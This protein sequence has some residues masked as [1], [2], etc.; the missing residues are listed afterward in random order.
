MDDDLLFANSGGD[1]APLSIRGGYEEEGVEWNVLGSTVVTA[2]DDALDYVDNLTLLDDLRDTDIYGNFHTMEPPRDPGWYQ[3]DLHFDGFIPVGTVMGIA[4]PWYRHLEWKV[5]TTEQSDG[6]FEF[7]AASKEQVRRS[8]EDLWDLIYS[9]SEHPRY[10]NNIKRPAE[11]DVSLLDSF[12]S[13]DDEAQ[14]IAAQARRCALSAVGWISWFTN[15]FHDWV[16]HVNLATRDNISKLHL[17]RTRKRG[18]LIKISRDWQSLDFGFLVGCD[19]PLLYT[20]G[21]FESNDRRFRRLCPSL[22]VSYHQEAL[23]VGRAIFNGDSPLLQGD[24]ET[25][26][27]YSKF[28]E[29]KGYDASLRED[30]FPDP[31]GAR[32]EVTVI[33]R[34]GWERRLIPKAAD[35]ANYPKLYH[36]CVVEDD[37]E[38]RITVVFWRFHSRAAVAPEPVDAD[39]IVVDYE[40]EVEEENRTEIHERFKGRYVPKLDQIFDP[41]TGVERRSPYQGDDKLERFEGEIQVLGRATDFGAQS[42]KHRIGPRASDWTVDFTEEGRSNKRPLSVSSSDTLSEQRRE[43]STRPMG[44]ESEWAHQ[45]AN[46]ASTANYKLTRQRRYVEFNPEKRSAARR[47][48]AVRPNSRARSRS[49]AFRTA[50]SSPIPSSSSSQS[51]KVARRIELP[52]RISYQLRWSVVDLE[53]MRGAWLRNFHV[54]GAALTFTERLWELDPSLVWNSGFLEDSYLMMSKSSK[55]RLR[56]WALTDPAIQYPPPPAP[57][58]DRAWCP[59]SPAVMYHPRVW[60]REN[61]VI[62]KRVVEPASKAARIPRGLGPVELFNAYSDVLDAVLKKPNAREVIARG[63]GA[64]WIARFF[65]YKRL[66]QAFMSGP[67]IQVT[68]HRGGGNDSGD[69]YPKDVSWDEL[70][71]RDLNVVF[72]YVAG[73]KPGDDAWIFPMDDTMQELSDHFHYEW[74][75]GCA[76][77]FKYLAQ[78]L[79]GSRG[80]ARTRKEWRDFFK[81]TNHGT[82]A[83]GT[84]V[85]RQ[86]IDDAWDRIQ[87]AFGRIWNKQRLPN[88]EIRQ[89]F[90]PRFH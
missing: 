85:T 20:W 54:F 60:E 51:V 44:F 47:V 33:D 11:F 87:E 30:N 56:Y 22:I 17:D 83:P 7:V 46:V 80:K 34:E 36:Y 78:E 79:I 58:S 86:Y 61:N 71:E 21:L 53:D 12:F 5:P 31:N 1:V 39:E 69:L 42:L 14:N 77:I 68:V 64:S 76:K 74:T 88:I 19:V 3:L 62:M 55:V 72:G 75:P 67:S 23:R 84:V 18:L 89:T 90:R 40:D 59:V 73:D 29:L 50:Q 70:S 82:R 43:D 10:D 65:S 37:K 57:E 49:P 25:C 24:F 81:A 52:E 32:F 45:V 35:W 15:A 8:L 66:A 13:S 4:M 9:L 26:Q 6:Q 48:E 41:R 38:K 28:L 16:S 27:L 63:G 2:S